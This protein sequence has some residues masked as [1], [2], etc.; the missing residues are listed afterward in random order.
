MLETTIIRDK[1]FGYKLTF[2]YDGKNFP[3]IDGL[4]YQFNISSDQEKY[5]CDNFTGL[6]YS[7]YHFHTQIYFKTKLMAKLASEYIEGLITMQVLMGE[8]GKLQFQF[9]SGF[10]IGNLRILS[11]G[12]MFQTHYAKPQP[13][14]CP[15]CSSEKGK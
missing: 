3:D 4:F 1:Y 8:T 14:S 5:L 15:M 13:Y 10:P 11:G 12:P 6:S 2:K 9:G 7:K